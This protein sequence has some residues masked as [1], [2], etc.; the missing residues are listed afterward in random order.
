MKNI[1][2]TI[3]R[4]PFGRKSCC[5]FCPWEVVFWRIFS[6]ISV[7]KNFWDFKTSQL[8]AQTIPEKKWYTTPIANHLSFPFLKSFHWSEAPPGREV[9]MFENSLRGK[10]NNKVKEI[11]KW[12]KLYRKSIIL[13]WFSN[14]MHCFLKVFSWLKQL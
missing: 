7:S 4:P 10:K 1:V 14:G 3:L 2:L 13:D 11:L 6:K 8:F 9:T 5:F 12:S